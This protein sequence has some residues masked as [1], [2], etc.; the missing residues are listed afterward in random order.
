MAPDILTALREH[1]FAYIRSYM[2][3]ESTIESLSQLGDILQLPG[4]PRIQVLQPRRTN[5]SSPNL[6][7]GNF[8]YGMY[9]LHTDLAHWFLPPHYLALRCIKGSDVTT[10]VF[11]A[12]KVV[13][14]IGETALRRTL[15]QS[16]RWIHGSRPLMRV[17]HYSPQGRH[18]IRWDELFI[19]PATPGSAATFSAIKAYLDATKPIEIEL[20]ELG[21]TLILDN[22][23]MLHGRSCVP[24]TAMERRIERA[25][26]RVQA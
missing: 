5:E 10:R 13:D 16:R 9:P 6:Y 11:D 3:C 12:M 8:G 24:Q 1:G 17:L 21:D 18:L 4:I 26:L 23:R 7:S 14:E 25:Y 20:R 2:P 22:W 15:V 19:S